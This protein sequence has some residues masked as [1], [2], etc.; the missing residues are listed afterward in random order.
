ML[1]VRV[2]EQ[3]H[4]EVAAAANASGVGPGDYL[5]ALI[6]DEMDRERE[7]REAG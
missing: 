4:A 7:A 1:F 2:S 6:M 3:T 5:R